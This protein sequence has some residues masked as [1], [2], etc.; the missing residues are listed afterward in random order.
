M[1]AIGLKIVEMG[2][3]KSLIMLGT[4]Y[5]TDSTKYEGDWLDDRRSGKGIVEV[6]H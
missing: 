1:R 2:K 4:Y 5:Y 6:S 3:V